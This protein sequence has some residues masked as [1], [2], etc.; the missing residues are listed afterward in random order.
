[1]SIVFL[2]C[3]S[4]SIHA[5]YIGSKVLV[6]L[7]ALHLG[8]SQATVGLLAALYAVVPLVLAV[9]TG[10]LADAKGM[11]LPLIIGAATTTV[12][13]LTGFFWSGLAG[14]FA[15]AL[16]M[17]GAFVFW[18]VSIQTLAGAIGTA[19]QRPRNFAWLSIGYSASNFIGPVFAGY[20]IDHG[21][22]AMTFLFFA[23]V[24]AIP[25]VL[26]AT[27]RD[28]A[29]V[30]GG[31]GAASSGGALDL[32]REPVL[33]RLII[34]SGLSVASSELFAFYVPVYTHQVGL[35][36]STT[37]T[38][39]GAYAI[40][41]LLTRFMLGP[42]TRWLR[43]DQIMVSF[44]LVA[45][46]AFAVFPMF[47]SA[48]AL[49]GVAFAIGIGVGCTQ[50]LLMATSFDKSPPGRAGEVTGLRLTANNLARIVMPLVSGVLGTA[51]G[52]SPVFWLNALNLAT[53]SFLS[54]R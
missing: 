30:H 47:T 18:N 38:I 3:L 5:C 42:L 28:L 14:L 22:H 54:R 13:M 49:M 10:K 2:V 21:G 36:A 34:I 29:G 24:P 46:A 31:K 43:T 19:E 9:Y 50:P 51:F 20:S 8:A 35:S 26:L 41:I 6:S 23:F 1:M 33:R 32:L 17:G 11:R 15:V 12:A 37:G 39:L 44:L 27:K 16:L 53:I 25:I 48:Y 40:A 45:A 7:Y 52:A 4:I